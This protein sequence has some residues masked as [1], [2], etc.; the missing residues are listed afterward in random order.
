MRFCQTRFCPG[1]IFER[2]TERSARHCAAVARQSNSPL[3][4]DELRLISPELVLDDRPSLR[5]CPHGGAPSTF[6]CYFLAFHDRKATVLSHRS[7]WRKMCRGIP[8]ELRNHRVPAGAET[9]V[10][11]CQ[12][13]HECLRSQTGSRPDE[14]KWRRVER[15]NFR[16]PAINNTSNSGALRRPVDSAQ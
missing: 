10:I 16:F 14:D 5:D 12:N 11:S 9:P 13:R 4:V 2:L 7:R 3:R 1:L 8:P 15:F 6:G